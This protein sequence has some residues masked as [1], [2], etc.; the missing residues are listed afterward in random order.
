MLERDRAA[1][2]AALEMLYAPRDKL[3]G[4][5]LDWGCC[6]FEAPDVASLHVVPLTFTVNNAQHISETTPR[7]RAEQSGGLRKVMAQVLSLN[8]IRKVLHCRRR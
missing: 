7:R 8:I 5:R 3:R 4:K 2:I 6:E 1:K